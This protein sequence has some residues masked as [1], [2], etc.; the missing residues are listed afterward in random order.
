MTDKSLDSAM[1]EATG[2]QMPS[3][4]RRMFATI[5]VFC[6]Y[7]DIRGLWE[8]HLEAMAEDYRRTNQSDEMVCQMVLRDVAD[9][10]RSMGRHIRNYDLPAIDEKG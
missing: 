7:T 1:V 10:I 8:R 2:F 6:E 4:L 5:I 9:V 3:A